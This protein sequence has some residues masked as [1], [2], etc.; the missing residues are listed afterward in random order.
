M[1]A[2]VP[3]NSA[4]DVPDEPPAVGALGADA[5]TACL[6]FPDALAFADTPSP[7][8]AR[9]WDRT[10]L[11][12]EQSFELIIHRG[13]SRFGE[14]LQASAHLGANARTDDLHGN[15]RR[16]VA[17]LMLGNSLVWATMPSPHGT[18]TLTLYFKVPLRES[19]HD[20]E[21]ERVF[22]AVADLMKT[23]NLE[24]SLDCLRDRLW[25]K[26]APR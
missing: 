25:S 6:R 23:S 11:A 1:T 7:A 12:H 24:R 10:F 8:S 3:A 17:D 22:A 26:A 2:C 9:V 21:G 19:V 16:S 5:V 13:P 15:G 4:A 20:A 14:E 18:F